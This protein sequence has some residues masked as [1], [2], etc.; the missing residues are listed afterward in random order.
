MS[1]K[2]MGWVWDQDLP[3]NEKFVLLAYADHADH[4][5]CNVYPSIDLIAVKTGYS[6]R[7]IQRITD[8]L[9]LKGYLLPDGT[10]KHGTNKYEIPMPMPTPV[11]GDRMTPP[12]VTPVAQGG[13]T[14]VSPEP[15]V[16]RH[17]KPKN[18]PTPRKSKHLTADEI[19]AA[20][21]IPDNFHHHTDFAPTWYAFLEHRIEIKKPMTERGAEMTLK[22]LDKYG[23][24]AAIVAMQDSIANGWQGVFPVKGNDMPSR[25]QSRS[26][27]SRE[28]MD[29]Y[30]RRDLEKNIGGIT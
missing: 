17:D 16:N 8:K 3:Q 19:L 26:A 21:I 11:G 10:S 6:R 5:G 20:V 27:Q 12:G 13:D 28:D 15:S 18:P 23:A 9:K 24:D 29:N 1:V 7:S 30:L 2:V 4:N 25:Q 22:K 14:A